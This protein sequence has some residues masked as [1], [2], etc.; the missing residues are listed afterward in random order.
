MKT[1]KFLTTLICICAFI[2]IMAVSVSAGVCSTH[3]VSI[4]GGNVK[5]GD[6]ITLRESAYLQDL[7]NGSDYGVQNTY[8]YSVSDSSI[9]KIT[10]NK[11]TFLKQGTVTLNIKHTQTFDK[12][13]K[14]STHTDTVDFTVKIDSSV[15]SGNG[16]KV[17]VGQT[18]SLPVGP[19][20]DYEPAYNNYSFSEEGFAESIGYGKI[21]FL[22]PGTLTVTNSWQLWDGENPK[23]RTGIITKTY[24][25]YPPEEIT[26]TT[27][28]LT[29]DLFIGGGIFPNFQIINN[30]NCEI[31]EVTFYAEM[32]DYYVGD[33]LPYYR[34]GTE[35]NYI[36]VTIKPN[37]GYIFA[38]DGKEDGK[39]YDTTK[40]K[41]EYAGKTYDAN[42]VHSYDKNELSCYVKATVASGTV[43][44]TTISDLE[45]PYHKSALDKEITTHSDV[46]AVSI[47]YTMF[48]KELTDFRNGDN[49][50]IVV[51]LKTKGKNKFLEDSKIYWK[52]QQ[53][54]SDITTLISEKEAEFVFTYK[55]TAKDEQI[56]RW[57]E[58]TM[59]GVY[60]GEA[61]PEIAFPATDGIK[62][63]SVTWTPNDAKV[64]ANK[65][66]TVKIEFAKTDEYIY[67]SDFAEQGVVSIN[68]ERARFVDESTTQGKFSNIKYFAEA[69]FK[70]Q[71]VGDV[72][73]GSDNIVTGT[74]TGTATITPSPEFNINIKY[75]KKN[76]TA[77]QGEK[78]T[79]DFTH[80]MDLM[81]CNN[82][83][84]QWYKASG[85]V[86]GTGEMIKGADEKQLQVDTSKPGTSYYY[87]IMECVFDDEDYSSDHSESTVVKVTVTESSEEEKVTGGGGGGGGGGSTSP[88]DTEEKDD[89][90][91][92]FMDVLEKDW[93]YAS[94][95]GAHKMGLINGKTETEYKPGDNMTYAEAV[96]LAV[97]MNILYNGGNPAKD[98]KNGTDKWYSTYMEYALDNGIIDEDLS[99]KANEKITRKE[100]VYIFSK[101]LPKKAF[102]EKNEIPEGS[103]PDVKEEKFAQDKAVYLFYRA[104][105]LS[106][107]DAKGTFNAN[108][109]IKRS[110]VAAILIRMMNPSVRVD[111]PKELGK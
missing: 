65:E 110:E 5:V 105:I 99:S 28:K 76:I 74:A 94:V 34:E 29:S 55:V 36:H 97:C 68:G 89:Y 11:L 10:E 9:A 52:E 20:N 12:T 60:A 90:K 66:Y 63:K 101:A 85:N 2:C 46:E 91:F 13:K 1:T 47:K 15:P 44:H 96:K 62:V 41:V 69:T 40:Y 17:Y 7:D 43:Y 83:R 38:F 84:Y 106:G 45:P 26:A 22:K 33:R 75:K 35:I 25:I 31:D 78:V 104:G 30:S 6:V 37:S 79:L 64:D 32:C 102:A 81:F 4:T 73:T 3:Y 59:P 16:V 58:F 67:A 18:V 50:G 92:P 53:V 71:V 77:E 111:A 14:T 49:I 72:N 24:D 86:Y 54:Y 93:F 42:V 107:V 27:I 70:P 48:G 23:P 103:I 109:N 98:I 19:K 100:Y 108:D 21:K 51:R 95:S 8:S 39:S 87:C 57:A 80:N 82:I 56:I 61:L 88:S